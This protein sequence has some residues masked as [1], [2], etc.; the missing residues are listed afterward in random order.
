MSFF[1]F[2]LLVW[3]LVMPLLCEAQLPD[4]VQDIADS[5]ALLR[6]IHFSS[7][8]GEEV[9]R[10]RRA[11][12][13][14]FREQGQHAAAL[15][16]AKQLDPVFRF[17]STLKSHT[18]TLDTLIGELLAVIEDTA[19]DYY[20]KMRCIHL[21]GKT[22]H[23]KALRFLMRNLALIEFTDKQGDASERFICL[24]MAYKQPDPWHLF[25]PLMDSLCEDPHDEATDYPMLADVLY[26]LTGYDTT[27]SLSL[28]Q[29]YLKKTRGRD[30]LPNPNL[31]RFY[32]YLQRE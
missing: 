18:A 19:T 17:D 30:G 10:A 11:Y 13:R 28:V 8:T 15:P 29:I 31:W 26:R 1:K 20:T 23:P 3:G 16:E 5:M 12:I 9:R 4:R 22:N 2:I 21:L 24:E 32:E 6:P 27:Y 14:L 25:Q 7:D